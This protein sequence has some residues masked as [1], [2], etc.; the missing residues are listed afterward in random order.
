MKKNLLFLSSLLIMLSFSIIAC[1]TGQKIDY[2]KM[3]FDEKIKVAKKDTFSIELV[4]NPST[5]YRWKY[6]N[7]NENKNIKFVEDKLI[8]PETNL[9]GA[10]GKQIFYFVAKKKGQAVVKL[11][12]ARGDQKVKKKHT[13][14]VDVAK[15]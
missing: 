5:G 1:K 10:A 4:S 2:S 11:E 7:A 3:N 9:I 12:Y 6:V 8:G 15:K 14:L 13:V